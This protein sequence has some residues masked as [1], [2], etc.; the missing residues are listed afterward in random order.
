MDD[1]FNTAGAIS[2]LFDLATQLNKAGAADSIALAAT[3]KTLGGRLGVL[4]SDPESW[5]KQGAVASASTGFPD[6][7][8]EALVADRISARLNKD[9]AESDRIRDLL[10]AEGV[11]VEDK[12]DTSTWR[13]Q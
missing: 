3:L 9:W 7:E 12:G 11:V 2:V 1:D 13:R 8:I 5:L 6:A 4:Q 10:S